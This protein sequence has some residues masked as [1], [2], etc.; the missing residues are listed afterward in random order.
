MASNIIICG[1]KIAQN[2]KIHNVQ[3]GGVLL[4]DLTMRERKKEVTKSKIQ[5]VTIQLIH[6]FGYTATTMQLVAEKADVA[7]R[8]LYNYYPSKEAI[9]GSYMR[10]VVREQEKQYWEEL[11]SLAT[12]YE[13]LMM[14]CNKTAEWT[15]E[16]PVLSEIYASDPRNF[17]YSAVEEVPRTG[18][19]ELLAKIFEI[20]QQE[21]DISKSVSI[22]VLVRQ[23]MGIL[24]QGILAWLGNPAYDLFTVF[25]EGTAVLFE[26]IKV[27]DV[28][29]G[30][31]FWGMFF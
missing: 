10:S 9:V 16:N 25:K 29:P 23:F 20:G 22:E 13:R 8:T 21:G 3:K 11:I 28:G 15:I 4:V 26:G 2:A 5:Q 19:E 6:E 27:R 30:T 31:V 18:L 24:Y 1:S 14:V 12:T 7:L 17:C